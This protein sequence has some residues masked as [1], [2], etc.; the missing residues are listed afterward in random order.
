MNKSNQ[1]VLMMMIICNNKNFVRN[2]TSDDI[3]DLFFEKEKKL[4]IDNILVFL[5]L[6]LFSL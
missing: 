4:S 5:V 1:L 2:N 3:I 6:F